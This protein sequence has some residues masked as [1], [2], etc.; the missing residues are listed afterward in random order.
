MTSLFCLH[1]VVRRLHTN[2]RAVHPPPRQGV[3]SSS[4]RTPLC[5]VGGAPLFPGICIGVVRQYP[6]FA[7]DLARLYD[8]D[9]LTCK[10]VEVNL[11]AF[12]EGEVCI[13]LPLH[14]IAPYV[15]ATLRS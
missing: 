2:R 3:K 10:F 15:T 14:E 5:L 7:G 13:R 9:C 12:V 8:D 6:V 4:R 1:F 11:H